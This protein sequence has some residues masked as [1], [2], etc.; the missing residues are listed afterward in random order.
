MSIVSKSSICSCIALVQRIY[1]S[2]SFAPSGIYFFRYKTDFTFLSNLKNLDL[3][4][5]TDLELSAVLEER[6][7]VYSCITQDL[8]AYLR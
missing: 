5:K 4:C 2:N 3:S 7:Q 1:S 6:S 8:F